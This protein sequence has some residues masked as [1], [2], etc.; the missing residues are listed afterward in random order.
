MTLSGAMRCRLLHPTACKLP[1]D[2]CQLLFKCLY[3]AKKAQNRRVSPQGLY[4]ADEERPL[5]HCSLGVTFLQQCSYFV[6]LCKKVL[7]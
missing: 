2:D 3:F 6:F 7:H 4:G 1:T 5:T